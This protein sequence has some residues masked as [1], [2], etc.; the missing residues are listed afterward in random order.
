MADQSEI[1]HGVLR[2]TGVAYPA[3]V[4]NQNRFEAAMAANCEEIAILPPPPKAFA[5]KTS[6]AALKNHSTVLSRLSK[7]RWSVASKGVVISP[8]SMPLG[9]YQTGRSGGDCPPP[10]SARLLRNFACLVTP[11]A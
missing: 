10:A 5:R 3:L 4:P 2:R 1:M 8:G 7:R 11:L 6:T 9:R